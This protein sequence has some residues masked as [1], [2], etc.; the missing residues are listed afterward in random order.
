MEG[1]KLL[2]GTFADVAFNLAEVL[3]EQEMYLPNQLLPKR[4]FLERFQLQIAEE[5][6]SSQERLKKG[7]HALLEMLTELQE[8]IGQHELDH[9]FVDELLKLLDLAAMIAHER[10]RFIDELCA[11][12]TLQDMA[13]ISDATVEKLYQAAKQL[14][15]QK[16]MQEAADAFGFLTMINSEKHAFWLALGNSEYNLKNYEA[17]LFDYAFA[18]RTNPEDH[19]CHIFS[20]RCYEELNDLDNA[21]NALE[22]A[23]YVIGDNP[24]Q[25]ELKGSLELQIQELE[26]AMHKRGVT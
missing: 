14:Y 13:G 4:I 24:D 23:I 22:L 6:K 12:K 19:L 26:R 8:Q 10:Q 1:V 18:Y 2:E 16:R 11:G 25:Q 9:E 20:C 21:K 15:E 7:P 17:A 3:A 5:L